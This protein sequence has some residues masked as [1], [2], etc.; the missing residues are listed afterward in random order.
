MA[1][2]SRKTKED[3]RAQDCPFSEAELKKAFHAVEKHCR[4]SGFQVCTAKQWDTLRHKW[5]DI[6]DVRKEFGDSIKANSVWGGIEDRI[7]RTEFREEE[8]FPL[9]SICVTDRSQANRKKW[10]INIFEK[11]VSFSG[12]FG[13]IVESLDIYD[14]MKRYHALP[15][16]KHVVT[17]EPYPPAPQKFANEDEGDGDI[18]WPSSDN[19]YGFGDD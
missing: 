4:L 3:I 13:V 6:D 5:H 8:C 10:I 7:F 11:A 1:V 17:H 19:S 9:G 2:Q 15:T 14:V 12:V 16:R 18:C